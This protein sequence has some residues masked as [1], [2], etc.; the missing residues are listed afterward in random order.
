MGNKP[1][2][3]LDPGH[4]GKDPGA[5]YK[6]V[7]EKTVTWN[8][9]NIIKD[10]LKTYEVEVNVVQPSTINPNSTANDELYLPVKKARDISADFYLSIHVNA[11]GGTGFESFLYK[12]ENDPRVLKLRTQLHRQIMNLLRKFGVIDRGEKKADFYVLRENY[13]NGIPAV[14]IECLFLDNHKD[15]QLLESSDF[16]DDLG[17]EIAYGLVVAFEL[18]KRDG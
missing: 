13:K 12:K 2:I 9:A 3:V 8:L 10:K 1:I 7:M 18:N 11:G 5:T 4:G 14:L 16:L 17:N 6:G 15:R